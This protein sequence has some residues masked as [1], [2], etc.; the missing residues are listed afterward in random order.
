MPVARSGSTRCAGECRLSSWPTSTL[1]RPAARSGW[2]CS[3]SCT[4]RRPPRRSRH[5]SI[6]FARSTQIAF[7][8]HLLANAWFTKER[9][10]APEII[11]AAADGDA[12]AYAAICEAADECECGPG[13]ANLL[14]L[15]AEEAQALHHRPARAV[16]REGLRPNRLQAARPGRQGQAGARRVAHTRRVG[17]TSHQR[18]H[19]SPTTTA[20]TR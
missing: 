19:A 16:R 2:S 10:I 4:T 9:K 7:R 8:S 15:P 6:I 14:G 17:R 5:S 20:S 18:H 12:E 1:S 13:W 3:D 11:E